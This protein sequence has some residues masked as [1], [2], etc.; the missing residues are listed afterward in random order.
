MPHGEVKISSVG[1]SSQVRYDDDGLQGTISSLGV[2]YD[3]STIC[4]AKSLQSRYR[5]D[6]VSPIKLTDT[7]YCLRYVLA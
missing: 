2:C 5:R 4:Y 7:K 1:P 6:R 3:L